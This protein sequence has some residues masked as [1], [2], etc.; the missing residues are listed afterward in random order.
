MQEHFNEN[1]ME[2][3]VYPNASFNGSIEDWSQNKISERAEGVLISGEM[4]IH[5]VTKTIKESGNIYSN[6][7]KIFGDATFIIK[8]SEYDV[9]IPKLLRENI[10]E[11]V[12]VN[13]QLELNKK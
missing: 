1:Y 6:N 2:S 4:T 12:E 9:K 5:G 11:K 7:G 3:E 13:I 8:L 10:A